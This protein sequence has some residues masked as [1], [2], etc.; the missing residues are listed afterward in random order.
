MKA[1]ELPSKEARAYAAMVT[2]SNYCKAH[3]CDPQNCL[4]CCG[5]DAACD[6]EDYAPLKWKRIVSNRIES[7]NSGG[8]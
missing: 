6:L 8:I 5:D 7:M 1:R 4:F 2:L 3:D